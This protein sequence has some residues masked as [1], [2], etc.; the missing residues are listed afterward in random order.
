MLDIPLRNSVAERKASDEH[1]AWAILAKELRLLPLA[2]CRRHAH[3][4]ALIEVYDRLRE[5]ILICVR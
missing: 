3:M 2:Y 5:R 4:L 1:M